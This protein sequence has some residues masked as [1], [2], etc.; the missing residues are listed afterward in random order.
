M[1]V[2]SFLN[3]S[4]L[5]IERDS[6][7]QTM[8]REMKQLLTNSIHTCNFSS[9]RSRTHAHNSLLIE[10]NPRIFPQLVQNRPH[11]HRVSFAASCSLQDEAN[12]KTVGFWSS[13]FTNAV[14]DNVAANRMAYA[15]KDND[16]TS[17]GPPKVEVPCGSLTPVLLDAFPNRRVHF[18]SLDVGT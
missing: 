18:F 6:R 2:Y 13:I 3:G 10:A 12:N 1:S 7:T 9:L 14:Q 8:L 11:A 17:R 15:D 16:T 5:Y 4:L